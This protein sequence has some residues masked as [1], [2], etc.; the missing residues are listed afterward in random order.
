MRYRKIWVSQCSRAHFESGVRIAIGGFDLVISFLPPRFIKLLE[1]AGFSGNRANGLREIQVAEDIKCG[2]RWIVSVGLLA[3]YTIVLETVYGLGETDVRSLEEI[4][5]TLTDMFPNSAY[6]K[7][8]QAGYEMALGNLPQAIVKYN[9]VL[10]MP[11]ASLPLRFG[12]YM[13]G[14]WSN[15]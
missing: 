6:I 8:L 1:F 12:V 4:M 11:Q 5:I 3:G 13:F 7:G 2:F 14:L 10:N 15:A 9:E